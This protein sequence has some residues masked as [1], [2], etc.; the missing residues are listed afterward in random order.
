MDTLEI[1]RTMRYDPY[2]REVYGGTFAVD[3][4]PN[5]LAPNRLYII[6]LDE[7]TQEGS[8]WCQASSMDSPLSVT[9]FDSFG[10]PPP[11]QI[12]SSLLSQGATILYSDIVIQSPMSQACGYHVLLVSLLQA[13]GYSL[14][15]ILTKFYQSEDLDYLRNDAYARSLISTLTAL[16]ERPL[17]DW[18][19]L[20][21]SQ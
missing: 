1:D 6:N 10:R 20:F 17:L 16:E 5:P 12:L 18:R 14:P 21:F 2:T 9:Y 15:E 19:Q 4:L 8:H 11:N 3:K 7:S 13:R